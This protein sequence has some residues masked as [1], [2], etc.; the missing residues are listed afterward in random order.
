MLRHLAE[1]LFAWSMLLGFAVASFI[2]AMVLTESELGNSLMVAHQDGPIENWTLCLLALTIGTSMYVL[3]VVETGTWS[4]S[5]VCVAILLSV[6][7]ALFVLGFYGL[8]LMLVLSVI[9]TVLLRRRGR[10]LPWI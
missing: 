9:T 10:R 5:L 3:R 4:L 6:A 2:A 1:R 7:A 8:I